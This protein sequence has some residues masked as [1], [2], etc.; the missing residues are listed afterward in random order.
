MATK[1]VKVLIRRPGGDTVT[2]LVFDSVASGD[3]VRIPRR[4]PFNDIVNLAELKADGF[5][6]HKTTTVS[7]EYG[8]SDVAGSHTELGLTLPRTEK[9]ILLAK[10]P[11]TTA[12]NITISGNTRAG[13]QEKTLAIPAG[14]AG[15]I[16]EID[17]FDLGFHIEDTVAKSVILKPSGALQL[18]LVAR[19]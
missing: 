16:Y 4:T 19:Y 11:G 8:G 14:T 18:L 2:K 15:D 10:N 5:I 17:I 7:S 1:N 9:L 13:V 12:V 3:V 6:R